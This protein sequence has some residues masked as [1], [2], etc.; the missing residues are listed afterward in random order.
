[1]N[2]LLV[3]VAAD[4]TSVGGGWNG[5]VDSSTGE[6]VYVP[7][8]ERSPFH[9]GLATPYSIISPYL[10]NRWPSLPARLSKCDM[11]LDP[12]FGH[13]TYGDCGARAEQIRSKLNRGD[14]LVFYSGLKDVHPSTRLVYAVIGL[15]VI[16]QI[17][18]AETV[19]RARWQE[20]AHTRRK[21]SGMGDIVVR[22]MPGVSGRLEQC[23]PIGEYRSPNGMPHKGPSYHVQSS[24][25]RQWGGL[26]ME[27]IQRSARLPTLNDAGRFYRW[28]KAQRARLIARN[29]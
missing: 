8:I 3:R 9:R 7:I 28:F 10:G 4:K 12:D 14:L 27:Y 16:A 20:N 13:L 29:N 1:M 26:D 23:L 2:G 19:P 21:S 22:A 11:H 5:P 15:Y 24:L 17:V 6:F 18:S 25:V